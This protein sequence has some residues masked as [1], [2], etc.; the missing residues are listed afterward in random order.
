LQPAIVRGL[1]DRDARVATALLAE[2]SERVLTFVA[3]LSGNAFATVR[4]RLARHLLDL[5]SERQAGPHLVAPLR[6]QE[7][8]DAIGTV[9]EVVVRVLRELREEGLVG[10]GRD[11]ITIHD[12]VGLLG[13][14]V[15]PGGTKV[16]D[17]DTVGA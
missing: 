16:P 15:L 3:E 9:R 10:T 13:S 8:A 1:A 17:K 2:T 7:L 14:A 11:G 5:A 4:Q 12:P 6:Q